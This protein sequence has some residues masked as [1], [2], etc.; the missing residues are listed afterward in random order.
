MKQPVLRWTVCDCTSGHWTSKVDSVVDISGYN[1]EREATTA[2]TFRRYQSPTSSAKFVLDN[3]VLHRQLLCA[4]WS[5]FDISTN[6]FLPKCSHSNTVRSALHP[7]TSIT[8][9]LYTFR[10]EPQAYSCHGSLSLL[11]TMVALPSCSSQFV[12]TIVSVLLLKRKTLYRAPQ[13][14]A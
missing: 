12:S 6:H 13:N 14:K 11:P 8:F 4:L 5:G 9:L 10:N 3:S 7:S 2:E 1:I